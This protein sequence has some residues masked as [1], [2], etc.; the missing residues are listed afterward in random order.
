MSDDYVSEAP[1]RLLIKAPKAQ[2]HVKP[3]I[4]PGIWV[5]RNKRCKRASCC[6]GIK[7][8]LGEARRQRSILRPMNPG[9][10]SQAIV[11]YRGVGA[12]LAFQICR[13]GPS[14]PYI[15]S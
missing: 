8:S 15:G 9:T 13:N 10:L 2:R 12:Q 4:A 11:E 1:K 3:G 6:A 14:A 5:C 7:F